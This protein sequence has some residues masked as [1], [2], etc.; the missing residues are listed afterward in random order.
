MK[1][2]KIYIQKNTFNQLSFLP[3]STTIFCVCLCVFCA[4]LFTQRVY[5]FTEIFYHWIYTSGVIIKIIFSLFF[6][7]CTSN[8]APN[9]A[10]KRKEKKKN[11]ISLSMANESNLSNASQ[12]INGDGPTKPTKFRIV[13]LFIFL[14]SPCTI[15][16]STFICFSLEFL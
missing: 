13:F 12:W 5:Q 6:F 8:Y 15:L 4:P 1:D 10:K 16:I 3:Y 11:Y 7:F 9:E 14:A 2:E